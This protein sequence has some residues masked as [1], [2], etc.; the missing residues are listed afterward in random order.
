MGPEDEVVT[1]V[2]VTDDGIIVL[3]EN[4]DPDI[5]HSIDS[6]LYEQYEGDLAL[7]NGGEFESSTYVG[8]YEY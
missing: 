3:S 7:E 2:E 8:E 5:C 1:E 4:A 6:Q